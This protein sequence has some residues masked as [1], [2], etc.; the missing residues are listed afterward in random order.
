MRWGKDWFMPS[1]LEKRTTHTQLMQQAGVRLDE[2]KHTLEKR[3]MQ[4]WNLVLRAGRLWVS[5]Q[6]RPLRRGLTESWIGWGVDWAHLRHPRWSELHSCIP[7]RCSAGKRNTHIHAGVKLCL[8]SSG[9]MTVQIFMKYISGLSQP[10]MDICKLLPS[11]IGKCVFPL[12]FQIEW[13]IPA[14]LSMRSWVKW[15]W[16]ML[17]D[18]WLCTNCGTWEPFQVLQSHTMFH[19]PPDSMQTRWQMLSLTFCVLQSPWERHTGVQAREK[20]A[21]HPCTRLNLWIANL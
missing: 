12:E 11:W 7:A 5:P 1:V 3:A 9:K 17:V 15:T 21:W 16:S 10:L 8:P 19:S 6:Y 4:H 2:E 20:F 18:T 13:A 14:T